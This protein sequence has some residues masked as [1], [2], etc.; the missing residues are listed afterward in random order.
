MSYKL[1]TTKRT[2]R[3]SRQIWIFY[4]PFPLNSHLVRSSLDTQ[5]TRS[6]GSVQVQTELN[7]RELVQGINANIKCVNKHSPIS[8]ERLFLFASNTGEDS[9]R[10]LWMAIAQEFVG[11]SNAQA[12]VSRI[13]TITVMETAD[14]ENVILIWYWDS[15]HWFEM[16][17]TLLLHC[18]LTP[19]VLSSSFENCILNSIHTLK[20]LK[21]QCH[22]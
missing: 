10:N 20:V 16:W 12:S 1:W 8:R 13:V 14:M 15:V 19:R 18:R 5:N 17:S 9:E 21:F 22:F 7:W 6:S 11:T 4:F 3:L 2:G